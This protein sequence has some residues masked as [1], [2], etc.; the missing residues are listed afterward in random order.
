MVFRRRFSNKKNNERI[1]SVHS[2]YIADGHHRTACSM[3]L[4]DEENK[5]QTAGFIAFL[6]PESELLVE[7]YNRIVTNLNGL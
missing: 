7:A 1:L 3:L 4:S 6:I 2:L 5:T